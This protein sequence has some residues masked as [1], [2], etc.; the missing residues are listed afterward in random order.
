MFN[1]L[2]ADRWATGDD[3]SGCDLVKLIMENLPTAVLW[4]L[5]PAAG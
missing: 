3:V 2:L 5:V 1:K 4:G